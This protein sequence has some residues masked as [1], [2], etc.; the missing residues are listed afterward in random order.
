MKK[1]ICLLFLCLSLPSFAYFPFPSLTGASGLTR[2]PDATVLPYKN[3][4]IS[5]DYGSQYANNQIPTLYYK[6]NLGTFQNF[7]LGLVG[8]L[9][10]TGKELRE[11]VFINMKYSPGIGDGSDPLLL[12]IGV[13]NLASKT[14]TALYMVA[15]KPF[16]Q[17]PRLSFGFL[18]DF[19]GNRFRP[20]GMAGID[21]PM[22]AFSILADL[23]A[24]ESL[25]QI[26]G[27]VRV[28][29]LPTFAIDVRAINI[30]GDTN[31][32]NQLGKDPKQVLFGISWIN[33]F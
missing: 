25:V 4:N 28:K 14:Q 16:K 11:G 30:F 21:V 18:A 26:N 3:W 31:N 22:D 6:A 10:Q 12:A 32:A 19:P 15:T 17:G 24:G 1:L 7:E 13:E 27:G 33:P 29:L 20:L 8:G 23:F 5:V 2:I 9:N